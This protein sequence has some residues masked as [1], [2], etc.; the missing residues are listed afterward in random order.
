MAVKIP[1]S[2]NLSHLMA[3]SLILR[4]DRIKSTSVIFPD[5]IESIGRIYHE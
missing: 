5:Q 3:S 1:N 4:A 2:L